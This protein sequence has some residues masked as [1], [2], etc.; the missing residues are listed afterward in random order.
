MNV[1]LKRLVVMVMLLAWLCALFGCNKDKYILDGPGMVNSHA[2]DS[3]CVSRSGDSYAQ[4]NFDICVKYADD[5]YV[6]TATL[7]NSEGEESVVLPKSACQQIDALDP[8]GLPDA[9]QSVPDESGEEL[10]MPLD[11]PEVE[12]EVG[13]ADGRLLRKVD[14]DDFS[15]KVYEIVAPYF[16]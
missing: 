7:I 5:G 15:L 9:V 12:I 14:Q 10:P 2:W 13:Y 16:E 8:A 4:H 1:K 11:F 6:V 3:F